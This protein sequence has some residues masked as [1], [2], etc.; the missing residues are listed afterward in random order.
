MEIIV[1][2][3]FN[4]ILFSIPVWFILRQLQISYWWDYGI[5]LYAI[6]VWLLLIG[7]FEIGGQSLTNVALECGGILL[8]S[9]FITLTRFLLYKFTNMNFNKTVSIIC[10]MLVICFAVLLRLF[11][12]TLPE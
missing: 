11:M 9:I 6:I 2:I 8:F 1:G 12:P 7:Y 3:L 5:S 4:A 10:I